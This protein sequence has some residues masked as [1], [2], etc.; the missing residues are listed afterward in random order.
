ME[1]GAFP[2]AT[3]VNHYREMMN[4]L[5]QNTP[6]NAEWCASLLNKNG[7]ELKIDHLKFFGRDH[8]AVFPGTGHTDIL[9]LPISSVEIHFYLN[10]IS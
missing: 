9:V 5:S 4:E 10:K 1:S 3:F 6:A 7:S 2:A 8:V